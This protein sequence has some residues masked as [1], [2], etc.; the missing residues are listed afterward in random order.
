M[1]DSNAIIQGLRRGQIGKTGWV[2][3][4]SDKGVIGH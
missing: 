2:F 4:E 3:E 1:N